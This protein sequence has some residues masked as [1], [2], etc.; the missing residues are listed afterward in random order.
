[1]ELRGIAIDAVVLEFLRVRLPEFQ[2][3]DV[4]NSQWILHSKFPKLNAIKAD[5]TNTV[6]AS[7][8]L[9]A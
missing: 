7:F 6:F 8:K 4:H 3:L 2:M 5:E 9:A 1:M